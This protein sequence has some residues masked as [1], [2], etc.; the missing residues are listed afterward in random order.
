M[1][2]L[3]RRNDLVAVGSCLSY[4][5]ERKEE[6][7]YWVW[8]H[9]LQGVKITQKKKLLTY[10]G[11]PQ[12]IFE[13]TDHDLREALA[14]SA[15]EILPET[16]CTART[17]AQPGN[18]FSY[19]SMRTSQITRV[20]EIMKLHQ[21]L[22][23]K[24][25]TY[26][27]PYYRAVA[28]EDRYAPL[29][30]YYRGQLH[31]PE[32]PIVGLSGSAK[33]QNENYKAICRY[34]R[35]R[36]F[37]F[38]TGVSFGTSREDLHQ[39]V[40]EEQVVYAFS[41][42]GLDHCYPLEAWPLLE[43]VTKKGA[44]LSEYAVGISPTVV[45][46]FKRNRNIAMWSDEVV[47]IGGQSQSISRSIVHA[48]LEYKRPVYMLFEKGERDTCNGTSERTP[49]LLRRIFSYHPQSRVKTSAPIGSENERLCTLI[50][51]LLQ[52]T[53]LPTKE[54]AAALQLKESK[55]LP[56]LID[57]ELNG[58]VSYHRS[59]SWQIAYE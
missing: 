7:I 23:I 30:Y 17:F 25:L 44:L 2:I 8:L 53:P 13:A 50:A 41:G 14:L 32:V 11:T 26:Q 20:E 29:V 3:V 38:A 5:K 54:L 33:E 15:D 31:N 37:A 51:D 6:E 45:R 49:Q 47:T 16:L 43:S 10:F 48:A 18:P 42:G 28:K 46:S 19:T 56:L 21:R 22:N 39:I 52:Y 57:L 35:S 1:A 58:A 12:A 59:G 55:L 24:V 9:E 34:Y 4:A 40:G 36:G 27:S